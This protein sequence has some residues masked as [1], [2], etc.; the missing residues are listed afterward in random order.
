MS[1]LPPLENLTDEQSQAVEKAAFLILSAQKQAAE[2]LVRA[3]VPRNGW[4]GSP[5]KAHI[6]GVGQC[7]C[8]NYTGDGGLCMTKISVDPAVPPF[9]PC[10]HPPSK[11]L[12][13]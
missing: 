7:P 11:H 1:K 12:P 5:C 2:M 10:N 13:T 4:F 8:S 6:E 9:D 3:G